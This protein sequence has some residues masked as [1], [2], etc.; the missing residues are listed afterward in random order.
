[1]SLVNVI[2]GR[3][4]FLVGSILLL[5]SWCCLQTPL[6]Y[7][8]SIA[9]FSWK[10]DFQ[11][12]IFLFFPP[13]LNWISY[14]TIWLLRCVWDNDWRISVIFGGFLRRSPGFEPVGQNRLHIW[15]KYSQLVF[16][17]HCVGWTYFLQNVKNYP[18][19]IYPAFVVLSVPPYLL[20]VISI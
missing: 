3:P 16:S 10:S 20:T 7:T 17:S 2:L 6:G 15:I 18:C 5:A 11:L 14:L 4:I 12:A 13:A 8:L 1:M 19:L 9:I